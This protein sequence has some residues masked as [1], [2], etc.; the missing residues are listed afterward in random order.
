MAGACA[1]VSALLDDGGADGVSAGCGEGAL[2]LLVG[3]DALGVSVG[4]AD[5]AALPADEGVDGA[6]DGC[7]GGASAKI[8]AGGVGVTYLCVE[9][10]ATAADAHI[11]AALF[12]TRRVSRI[13]LERP[14]SAMAAASLAVVLASPAARLFA[15]LSARI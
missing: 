7:V 11:R 14:S 3:G 15:L 5:G 6:S 10:A 2:A 9:V 13:S 4:I 8:S 1:E 12:L